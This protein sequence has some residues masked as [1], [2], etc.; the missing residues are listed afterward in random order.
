MIPMR[1]TAGKLAKTMGLKDRSRI[2]RLM[3][4][5][6]SITADTALRLGLVLGTTAEFWMNLQSAYDL[7]IARRK[8]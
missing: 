3:R 7:E 1:L 5:R 8:A 6:T 4:N 2:E